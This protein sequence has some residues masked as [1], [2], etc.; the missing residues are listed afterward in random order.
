MTTATSGRG[1]LHPT[2]QGWVDDG[3]AAGHEGFRGACAET[4]CISKLVEAGVDTRGGTLTT[5]AVGRPGSA[6]HGTPTPPC[7]NCAYV[8]ERSGM[9]YTP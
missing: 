6:R 3:I 7:A 4:N 8:I 5:R 1:L 9:T 2:V